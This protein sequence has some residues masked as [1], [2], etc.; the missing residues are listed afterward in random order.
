VHMVTKQSAIGSTPAEARHDQLP[1]DVDHSGLAKFYGR[2]DPDYV[3]LR[4]R[5]RECV[6]DAPKAIEKR[7]VRLNRT[8]TT[9]TFL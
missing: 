9:S 5:I 1:R 8:Y 3:N 7:Y 6:R 4:G 2:S